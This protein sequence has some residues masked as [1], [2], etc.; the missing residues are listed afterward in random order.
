MDYAFE[1][2][3]VD[4]PVGGE[5]RH[6][7]VTSSKLAIFEAL[8]AETGEFVFARDMGIQNV[9]TDIDPETGAK[10]FDD[11]RIASPGEITEFCPHAG[12]AR[13]FPATAYDAETHTLFI[14][15][16]EHCARYEPAEVDPQDGYP[17]AAVSWAV[18]PYQNA[19]GDTQDTVGR[20]EALNLETLETEWVNRPRSPQSTGVLLTAGNLVF[21]GSMDRYFT[22]YDKTTGEQLWET[23]LGDIPNSFPIT[24][25]ADGRQ[26]VAVITGGGGPYAATWGGMMPDILLPPQ[27]GSEVYVFALPESND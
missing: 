21:E 3:L 6:L 7:V 26:Y 22:A 12:G 24:Y 9:I 14:P 16:Q 8:D 10:T 4:L 17:G 2:I 11:E 27:Q 1:R 23:R 20:L 19:E 18:L 25:E 15:M 5:M 13:S